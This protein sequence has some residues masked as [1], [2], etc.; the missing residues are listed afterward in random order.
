MNGE[1]DKQGKY[2]FEDK[3]IETRR[4]YKTHAY[5]KSESDVL[6]HLKYSECIFIEASIGQDHYPSSPLTRNPISNQGVDLSV[7][8]RRRKDLFR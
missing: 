1:E 8:I 5:L 7:P 3:S 4:I 2:Y 6:D